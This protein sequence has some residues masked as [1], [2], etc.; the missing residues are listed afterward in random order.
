MSSACLPERL[1]RADHLGGVLVDDV[2]E[3]HGRDDVTGVAPG[4]QQRQRGQRP[5]VPVDGRRVAGDDVLVPGELA[6]GVVEHGLGRRRRRPRPGP[7]PRG[8]RRPRPAVPGGPACTSAAR[9]WSWSRA[10]LSSTAVVPPGWS[11][12]SADAVVVSGSVR[13]RAATAARASRDADVRRRVRRCERRTMPPPLVAG[14][15]WPDGGDGVLSRPEPPGGRARSPTRATGP[16]GGRPARRGITETVI[17]PTY[18][19]PRAPL[20]PAAW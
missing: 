4:E 13:A 9:C 10:S 5:A 17:T 20:P 6:L 7:S 15:L 14:R 19:P 2:E 12:G 3:A 18:R 1:G 16:G 8:R 11:L